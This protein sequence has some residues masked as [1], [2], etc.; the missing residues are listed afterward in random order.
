MRVPS[1]L[2]GKRSSFLFSLLK[3][4]KMKTYW[5]D[6]SDRP[7][8][9]LTS[10]TTRR[11]SVKFDTGICTKTCLTNKLHEAEYFLGS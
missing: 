6:L 7:S 5:G 8:A 1:L 9:S 4:H 2:A 10:E 3:V 11:I